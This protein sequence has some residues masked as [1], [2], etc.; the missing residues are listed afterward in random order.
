MN[1]LDELFP[2]HVINNLPLNYH[3]IKKREKKTLSTGT[4]TSATC[5]Y[6]NSKDYVCEPFYKPISRIVI[7]SNNEK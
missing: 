2:P 7:T 4:L 1:P 6:Y 3:F 5:S